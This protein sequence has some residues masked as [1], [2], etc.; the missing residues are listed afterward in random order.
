MC[1]EYYH[2]CACKDR[3]LIDPK[4]LTPIAGC[5]CGCGGDTMGAAD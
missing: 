3:K 5:E 2:P 1:C 4:T